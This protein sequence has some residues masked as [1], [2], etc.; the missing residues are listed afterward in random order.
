MD[1]QDLDLE[2]QGRYIGYYRNCRQKAS[3]LSFVNMWS[4]MEV[5]GLQWAFDRDLVW[6][7]QRRPVEAYWPPAGDWDRVDWEK[8]LSALPAGLR[9][10]RVPEHLAMLWKNQPNSRV[11]LFE[12]REHWDYVYSVRELIELKGNRYHNKKQL[13]NQF[14]Q[15]YDFTF[16]VMDDA[17][18]EEAL[19]LQTEWC[20]WR[21]CETSDAL[22]EENKA[23]VRTLHDWNQLQGVFGAGIL[24][25]GEMVAY[26]VGEPLGDDTL[27]IH[28]E[29]ACPSIVGGYQ[30]INQ[31]FLHHCGSRFASVNRE[32]DLGEEGLRKAK[33]SYFPSHFIKK[34]EVL[35]E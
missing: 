22:L 19:A 3:D 28:Y 33:L 26:T 17:N 27:V 8:I 5:Y 9:F 29:K 24:V 11:S 4:W 34:Y 2:M 14:L 21:D 23:I 18:I 20:A 16:E 30:A 13:L 6:I 32:Q 25:D 7:R 15:Q 1:F 10:I 35:L 12:S 31:L